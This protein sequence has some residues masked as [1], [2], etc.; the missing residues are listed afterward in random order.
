MNWKKHI[1]QIAKELNIEIEIIKK[2]HS[3][4]PNQTAGL[5]T[6]Y[7]AFV[8]GWNKRDQRS[9]YCALHELGHI[10]YGHHKELTTLNN[11]HDLLIE[12]EK[13]A[14]KYSIEKALEE[15]EYITV[16]EIFWGLKSYGA[17]TE[18]VIEVLK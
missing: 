8:Y 16:L 12:A 15:P 3:R 14:W 18:D 6:P 17:E 2:C 4:L 10:H 7:K 1:K 9:Y 5:I 11:N 13:L